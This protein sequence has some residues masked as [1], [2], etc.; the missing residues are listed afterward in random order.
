M[1]WDIWDCTRAGLEEE[2]VRMALVVWNICDC[3]CVGPDEVI[4]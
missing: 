2:G 3:T 4:C 1:V